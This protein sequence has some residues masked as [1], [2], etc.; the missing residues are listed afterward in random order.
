MSY[1]DPWTSNRGGQYASKLNEYAPNNVISTMSTWMYQFWLFSYETAKHWG[2]GPQ[3]WTA[4]I[5]GFHNYHQRTTISI[6]S[7]GT[8]DA[9]VGT[10]ASQ[11]TSR[12]EETANTNAE[13][14]AREPSSLCRWSIHC[15]T[16]IYAR[17]PSPPRSAPDNV[18][19]QD[20]E[21]WPEWSASSGPIDF[22][23]KLCDNLESN[24][25]STITVDKL[26]IAVNQIAGAARRSPEELAIEALGFTIMGR[27]AELL[28]EYL[29]DDAIDLESSGLYPFHLAISYLDGA[30]TCCDILERL[31][32][33]RPLSLRK[34]YVN[35]FGHTVLDQLMIAILKAHTSC[36][37]SVVDVH[38]KK[39]KRFAGEDVDICGRW[40]A[41][42]DCIRT[43]LA[44][45]IAG[46][47]FEWKHMFCH[48]SVQTIC[49][50]MGLVFGPR[51]GPDINTPSGLFLRHCS[52]CGLKLQLLPLHTLV[53]V[54]LH[55]SQ[56]GCENE[57]LFGILACLL[58]VLSNGANPLLKATISMQAFLT[59][60]GVTDCN[61]EEMDPAEFAERLFISSPSM[62]SS[63]LRI[64]WQVVCQVLKH[65]RSTWDA[66]KY[67]DESDSSSDSGDGAM[68][69]DC[70]HSKTSSGDEMRL[71]EESGENP[72]CFRCL[73]GADHFF[74]RSKVL[75]SL[76]ASI[77][78]ELLTY[79][80]LQEGDG[81]ISH[82]FDMNALNESLDR[83]NKL[84]IALVRKEMMKP[85]CWGG[86][87][88]GATPACPIID[89]VANYYF[90]NLEDWNR[91]TFLEIVEPE[92]R[93]LVWNWY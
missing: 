75:A 21:S 93:S 54:G 4:D 64:G 22:T 8:P 27:N 76:W 71:E 9:G 5:L 77:Q 89:D 83:G 25:F 57:N 7:P 61:H 91:T 26:P 15:K 63:E 78:T 14:A 51:W 28:E 35:D 40:D 12:S 3:D 53:L 86:E 48:T 74:G 47:P 60:D 24:N 46:I 65:S 18:N 29:E 1:S 6:S 23:E 17:I 34:L 2:R 11:F 92:H 82:N 33:Y 52:S 68:S 62:G 70:E 79:R 81:W 13:S 87:F 56:S 90:S 80:R 45:G 42:S 31:E 84:D 10:P 20:E 88:P 85:Y 32:G 55:L 16:L 73:Y 72:R 37:P 36:L 43:L 50:C 49:H 66:K 19:L 69:I 39:D 41:D 58:C 44:N 59:D 38:F 67:C 30:K